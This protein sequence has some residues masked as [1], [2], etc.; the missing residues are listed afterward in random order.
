MCLVTD[1][2]GMK[3]TKTGPML[4]LLSPSFKLTLTTCRL[5]R[6]EIV[7][8]LLVSYVANILVLCS[9]VI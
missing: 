2:K 3:N 6:T 9:T 4:C 1:Q 7:G 5:G 8:P